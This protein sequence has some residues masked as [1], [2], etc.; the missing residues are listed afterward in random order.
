VKKLSALKDLN[1]HF[2]ILQKIKEPFKLRKK[3]IWKI[4]SKQSLDL[5]NALSSL[6][7]WSYS[8]IIILIIIRS[9]SNNRQL[10]KLK[11]LKISRKIRKKLSLQ[12]KRKNL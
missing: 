12:L 8:L 7:L 1:A 11:S 10:R 9:K 3:K 2:I 5:S 4:F 6:I